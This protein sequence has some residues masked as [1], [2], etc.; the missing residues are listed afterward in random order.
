MG[1]REKALENYSAAEN[2][3]RSCGD[4]HGLITALNGRGALYAAIG[5]ERALDCHNE[6]LQLSR[7]IGDLQGQVVALRFLGTTYHALGDRRR[8]FQ[9]E[10]A[11]DHSYGLALECHGEALKL[12][13]IL[14]DQRVEAYILQELGSISSSLNKK[15]E[16]KNFYRK[17]LALSRITSDRRGEAL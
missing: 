9:D 11:A 7:E 17:A 6:A 16:A 8:T 14:K 15:A 10:Q 4:R 12:S 3:F 5:S 1:E 13:G 2:I